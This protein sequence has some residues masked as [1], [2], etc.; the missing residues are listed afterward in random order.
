V[1]GV[2]VQTRAEF[3][4]QERKIAKDMS[5]DIISIMN[6]AGYVTG[7]AVIVLTVYIATIARR[8]EY[9][10]LKA[11]GIRNGRLYQV[12]VLQA[13][14]SVGLGLAAA[15]GITLLL[16]ESIPRLNELM[17]LTLTAGSVLRVAAI[18]VVLAGVAAILP[19]RQLAGLEPVTAMRRGQR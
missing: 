8:R 17:V 4:A 16:S 12:V 9:G 15:V 14:I 10:V 19:A 13:L 11:I 5:A 7:L 18:S 6:T 2:S 3:A 1:G